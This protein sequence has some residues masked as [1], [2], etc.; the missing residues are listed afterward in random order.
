MH[1]YFPHRAIYIC[2]GTSQVHSQTILSDLPRMYY[3]GREMIPDSS[4]HFDISSKVRLR[5]LMNPKCSH[6]QT[7]RCGIILTRLHNIFFKFVS[8]L[9]FY[10][11][12]T[13]TQGGRQGVDYCFCK[14]HMNSEVQIVCSGS[15]TLEYE[16]I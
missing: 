11:S 14:R 5:G 7:H 2:K 10:P 15:H 12:A 8:N 1:N 16:N 4:N 3:L 9:L 6:L 13:V